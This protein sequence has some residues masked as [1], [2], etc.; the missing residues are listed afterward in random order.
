MRQIK[1]LCGLDSSPGYDISWNLSRLLIGHKCNF[2]RFY[3]VKPNEVFLHGVFQLR[4]QIPQSKLYFIS[5]ESIIDLFAS[6]IK[7][8]NTVYLKKLEYF[9]T[10]SS[11]LLRYHNW[12]NR[13][14]IQ[15]QHL[16]PISWLITFSDETYE[17]QNELKW[18]QCVK[19]APQVKL[20]N[21]F[22]CL[23]CQT[24]KFDS[25]QGHLNHSLKHTT[26]INLFLFAW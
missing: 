13:N 2:K 4:L 6:L 16:E 21:L 17:T 24:L 23:D 10:L 26:N 8:M 18:P 15:K 22:W 3:A 5:F 12:I 7:W 20:S 9:W 1:T 25:V 14:H 19:N 11:N